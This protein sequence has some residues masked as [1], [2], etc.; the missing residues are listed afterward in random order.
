MSALI[1]VARNAS[2]YLAIAVLVPGGLVIAPL[3]WLR[4]S[5]Y[6]RF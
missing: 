3:L 2:P 5:G 1:Q 4:K 6:L